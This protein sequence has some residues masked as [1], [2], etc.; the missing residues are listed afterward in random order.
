MW[1]VL[2][3]LAFLFECDVVSTLWI[4]CTFFDHY[5]S[6]NRYSASPTYCFDDGHDLDS[7]AVLDSF[8]FKYTCWIGEK[9][10]KKTLRRIVEITEMLNPCSFADAAVHFYAPLRTGDSLI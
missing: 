6:C 4:V 7:F 5:D 9:M 8:S 1:L 10:T 3:V 2:I